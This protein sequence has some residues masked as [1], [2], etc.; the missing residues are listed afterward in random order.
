LENWLNNFYLCL[1]LETPSSLLEKDL[2]PNFE[3]NPNIAPT[4]TSPIIRTNEDEP[5]MEIARFGLVH[6][7]AKDTKQSFQTIPL[8]L[9]GTLIS[10]PR[11]ERLL[12]NGKEN[13][14]I[15]KF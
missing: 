11:I 6:S 14:R 10:T 12:A 3:Y 1:P 8:A 4:D 5:K 13:Q 15:K 9:W 7:W 2:S